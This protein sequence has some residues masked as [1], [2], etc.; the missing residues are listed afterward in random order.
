V[1]LT[2]LKRE[3]TLASLNYVV[4]SSRNILNLSSFQ[5]EYTLAS[6]KHFLT[7]YFK[8]LV[9]IRIQPS[10]LPA[11]AQHVGFAGFQTSHKRTFWTPLA[12]TP[13]ETPC[14]PNDSLTHFSFDASADESHAHRLVASGPQLAVRQGCKSG[15]WTWLDGLW[16]SLITKPFPFS[17]ETHP[18]K[19]FVVLYVRGLLHK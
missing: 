5:K 7:C 3:Y 2:L 9:G 12:E 1:A 6:F 4:D 8:F 11:V 15:G 19:S 10:N 18:S 17:N 13:S 16:W 14:S